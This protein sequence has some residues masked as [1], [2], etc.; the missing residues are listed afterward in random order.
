MKRTHPAH[1]VKLSGRGHDA[2]MPE[3]TQTVRK[4]AS[5]VVLVRAQLDIHVAQQFSWG[6]SRLMH[7]MSAQP[8]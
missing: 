5:R 4:S 6:A 8:V 1:N 3:S 7:D 2:N